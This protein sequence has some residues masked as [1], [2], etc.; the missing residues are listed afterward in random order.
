M[1]AG[2][3]DD[4]R[5]GAAAEALGED[6]V[7]APHLAEEGAV[8]AGNGD[9]ITGHDQQVPSIEPARLEAAFAR[10]AHRLLEA[11]PADEP[12]AATPRIAAS[13]TATP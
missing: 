9:P 7:P 2:A 1:G 5:D 10:V 11:A 6:A 12:I 8:D 4:Q 13:A 3:L